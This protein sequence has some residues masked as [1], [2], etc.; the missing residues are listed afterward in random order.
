M[1]PGSDRIIVL[2]QSGDLE[3]SAPRSFADACIVTS[4]RL[5][6]RAAVVQRSVL[7]MDRWLIGEVSASQNHP[8][9]IDG[10]TAKWCTV[11]LG[12]TASMTMCSR[13][14]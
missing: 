1:D 2:A 8:I 4:D 5:A 6:A 3:F 7:I 9:A 13:R 10:A 12:L 14:R 11:A